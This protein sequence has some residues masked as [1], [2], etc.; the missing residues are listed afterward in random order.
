MDICI[1]FS[2][3]GITSCI[4]IFV[5]VVVVVVVVFFVVVIVIVFMLRY[6]KNETVRQK[7]TKIKKVKF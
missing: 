3:D 5:V 4:I 2:N 1:L 6:Y 7:I